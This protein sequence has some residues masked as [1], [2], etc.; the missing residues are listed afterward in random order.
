MYYFITFPTDPNLLI[1]LMGHLIPR[2][3]VM[4]SLKDQ[5][6]D[7]CFFIIYINDVVNLTRF[8]RKNRIS[9]FCG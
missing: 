9:V 2:D 8:F 4:A 7:R 3:Y 5:S 1:Y 6:K